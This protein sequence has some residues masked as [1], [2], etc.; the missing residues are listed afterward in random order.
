MM[1]VPN[2]LTDSANAQDAA[3]LY[4]VTAKVYA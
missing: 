2:N 3:W 1:P 4:Y